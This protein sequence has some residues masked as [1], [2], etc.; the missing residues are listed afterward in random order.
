VDPFKTAAVETVASGQIVDIC[1][2]SGGKI[3]WQLGC[4]KKIS[5]EDDVQIY[6]L[7]NWKDGVTI[8]S[9]GQDLGWNKC[10]RKEE[11]FNFRYGKLQMSIKHLSV[12]IKTK[13]GMTA[14]VL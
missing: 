10:L 8:Y 12:V 3:S 11:E 4:V 2:D 1:D 14:I 7:S 5:V 6:D 13:V 9:N